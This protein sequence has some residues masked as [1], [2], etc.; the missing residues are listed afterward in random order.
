MTLKN[1]FILLLIF[2]AFIA[3]SQDLRNGAH[4]PVVVKAK[5]IEGNCENGKGALKVIYK[6][7][8]EKNTVEKYHIYKGTFTNEKLNGW[9]EIAYFNSNN[10]NTLNVK[11]K[12][13][14]GFIA[15]K[16]SIEFSCTNLTGKGIAGGMSSDQGFY[17]RNGE[18][19]A[20][21]PTQI[22][23]FI[24]ENLLK[25]IG[26][27]VVNPDG[28]ISYERQ[29]EKTVTYENGLTVYTP[30]ESSEIP[31][32]MIFPNTS[33]NFPCN[34]YTHVFT[35]GGY[36]SLTYLNEALRKKEVYLTETLPGNV[37]RV[38]KYSIYSENL[39][40]KNGEFE[41][42]YPDG[43][44]KIEMYKNDVVTSTKTISKKSLDSLNAVAAAKRLQAEE[45][46]EDYNASPEGQKKL[47]EEEKRRKEARAYYDKKTQDE[48][49][50][51]ANKNKE[52]QD[53][54]DAERKA[55]YD[56]SNEVF[57]PKTSFTKME[58]EWC[59][60]CNGGSTS[61]SKKCKFCVNGVAKASNENN[62]AKYI[63]G[64]QGSIGAVEFKKTT[65]TREY[66]CIKCKGT[67]YY[68][69]DDCINPNKK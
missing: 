68:H 12:F 69:C 2:S 65:T 25:Y 22:G 67:G 1:S 53:K 43:S 49:D 29:A 10:E 27:Y 6:K 48:K 45:D 31:G 28:T 63:S 20:S 21:K 24:P 62:T 47:A 35:G 64:G 30:V 42:T 60:T 15:A 16:D 44:Y 52:R 38:G 61:K 50:Y 4:Y 23:F 19:I 18:I 54:K 9:G 41:T 51:W 39:C 7:N 36:S 34:G 40:S 55:A 57:D 56:A 11:C 5:C 8:N 33:N 66:N 59:Y 32:K 46:L 3:K 14:N 17:V 13:Y 58:K 37:K 26:S